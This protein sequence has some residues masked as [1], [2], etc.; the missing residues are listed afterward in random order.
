MVKNQWA[1]GHNARGRKHSDEAKAKMRKAASERSPERKARI[2]CRLVALNESRTGQP[3]AHEHRDAIKGSMLGRDIT[4]GAGISEALKG[5]AVRG[6]GWEHSDETKA[7][8]SRSMRARIA[9]GRG[10]DCVYANTGPELAVQAWLRGQGIP[11]ETHVSTGGF[12]WDII[13][14]VGTLIEVNGCYWHACEVCGWNDDH[15]PTVAE[16]DAERRVWADAHGVTFVTLWEH[17]VAAGDFSKL[18]VLL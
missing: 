11:F 4:W 18:E 10:P 14:N 5:R 12:N 15:V 13:T 6:A 8:M 9:E 16:R 3:L 7:K 2:T 1:Q 17:E